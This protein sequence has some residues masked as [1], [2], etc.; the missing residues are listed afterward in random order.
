M[1]S[2]FRICPWLT[3]LW[4]LKVAEVMTPRLAPAPRRPQNKSEFCVLDAVT[5]RPS[6]TT[7][8]AETNASATRPN[9]PLKRPTPDPN[10]TPRKPG[11]DM[12]PLS[13]FV[14]GNKNGLFDQWLDVRIMYPAAN[15]SS[16]KSARV[17]APPIVTCPVALAMLYA[18]SRLRS[19]AR[20]PSSSPRV[21]VYP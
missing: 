2:A 1:K 20:P 18:L 13:I 14:S 11:Q 19:I 9:K 3:S 10:V 8:R 17:V 6:A 15:R 16:W 21:V 4:A 12:E 7:T 5:T